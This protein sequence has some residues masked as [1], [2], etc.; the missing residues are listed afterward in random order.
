MSVSSMWPIGPLVAYARQAQRTDLR[1]WSN[2]KAMLDETSIGPYVSEAKLLCF[3]ICSYLLEDAQCAHFD[4]FQGK[5]I[6]YVFVLYHY[7]HTLVTCFEHV[8]IK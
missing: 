4:I 7:S 1:P 2:G 5:M 6:R 3:A 8:D